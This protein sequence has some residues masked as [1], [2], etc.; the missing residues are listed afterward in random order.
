MSKK[1]KKDREVTET[2]IDESVPPI[3]ILNYICTGKLTLFPAI[4]MFLGCGAGWLLTFGDKTYSGGYFEEEYRYGIAGILLL[5]VAL[6]LLASMLIWLVLRVSFVITPNQFKIMKSGL[7]RSS[8]LE[9]DMN[10]ISLHYFRTHFIEERSWLQLVV[11]ENN[12]FYQIFSW[13]GKGNQK[14]RFK[15]LF[16]TL[17]KTVKEVQRKNGLKIPKMNSEI[18]S[19]KERN[20]IG[21]FSDRLKQISSTEDQEYPLCIEDIPVVSYDSFFNHFKSFKYLN[22][23]EE[24][25]AVEE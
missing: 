21:P 6:G 4:V 13:K 22:F 25:E 12:Q 10:L 1:S 16:K 8:T 18:V 11:R 14:E 24:Q 19:T 2:S 20:F 5:L 3:K 23:L 15:R 17:K 9:F 7:L